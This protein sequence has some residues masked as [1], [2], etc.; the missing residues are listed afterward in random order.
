M[1][2]IVI[3]LEATCWKNVM[4]FTKMEII[5]I[6]A[7]RLSGDTLAVVDKFSRFVRPWQNPILSSFCSD[8]TSIMQEDVD[9]AELFSTVFPQFLHWIGGEDYH[10]VTWGNYDIKQF[11]IDCQ[12]HDLL[13]P[14]EFTSS[15]INLKKEFSRKVNCGPCGMK[16]ALRRLK[17]P[18]LGTHHRGIDDARNIA[19]IAQIILPA[20]S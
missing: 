13:L 10:V 17:L 4:D 8:L 11:N 5:E 16:Q 1:Q 15:Y 18:L 19:R 14:D 12:R 6:G 7:V 2:Y 20:G 3:D 9:N